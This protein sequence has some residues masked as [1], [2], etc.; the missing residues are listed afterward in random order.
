MTNK[1]TNK[2]KKKYYRRQV[3]GVR[4][5]APSEE[6]L[7]SK[8]KKYF[9]GRINSTIVG[10]KEQTV[11]DY[12]IDWHD[13]VKSEVAT[14]TS[15]LYGYAAKQIISRIGKYKICEITPLILEECVKDFANTKLKDKKYYPSQRY[16]NVIINVLNIV[17]KRA[18]RELL[19]PF[20]YADGI[21]V[22]SKSKKVNTKHRALTREEINRVL[23]FNHPLRPYCLFMLLC[24]LM[25]EETVALT[26]GDIAY[27]SESGLYYVNINKTVELISGSQPKMRQGYAKTE[28]RFRRIGIPEPL[29]EWVSSNKK[30]HKNRELIFT[31]KKGR[32]L[33][34]SA[35]NKKWK[36]YLLDMDIH[37]NNKCN[38]YNPTK[39]KKLDIEVF[40]PYDL[41]HT[42]AT[43]LAELDVPVRK[44]TALMGHSNSVTTDKYYVDMQ[45]LDTSEAINLLSGEM[46]KYKNK[47]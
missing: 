38:K 16:I 28:Y 12:I 23:N 21:T 1:K 42:Y 45:K 30:K 24:G 47:Q 40:R 18:Q 9:N 10:K 2:S 27:D 6:E 4:F 39:K 44:T 5:C 35:L 17:F 41:R 11:A 19:I 31:N 3:D 36:S 37:Y 22:K 33:S 29:S 13:S 26:W 20:N 43:M 14:S 7:D 15:D 25:P 8:I 46:A 32:L 34:S